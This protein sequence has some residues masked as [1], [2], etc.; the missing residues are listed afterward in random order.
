M[1]SQDRITLITGAGSGIGRAI[2][3]RLAAEEAPVAALDMNAATAR[4]RDK[5]GMPIANP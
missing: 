2:A 3:L 4:G 5:R 1:T